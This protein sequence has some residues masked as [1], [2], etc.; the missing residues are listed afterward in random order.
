MGKAYLIVE[1]YFEIH[2]ITESLSSVTVVTGSLIINT[3]AS[4]TLWDSED[5][6]GTTCMM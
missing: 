4:L 2:N 3:E 1:K 5:A 6:V